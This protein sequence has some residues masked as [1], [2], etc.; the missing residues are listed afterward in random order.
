MG[1]ASSNNI[2]SMKYANIEIPSCS[3]LDSR[4]I[5]VESICRSYVS[6]VYYFKYQANSQDMACMDCNEH[7][8]IETND[9][10]RLLVCLSCV[11][12]GCH[13]SRNSNHQHAHNH[14]SQNT[15][16]NIYVDIT[17][18][19]L[20]SGNYRPTSYNI[21]CVACDKMFP[22]L[23]PLLFNIESPTTIQA[24]S[25][26]LFFV[27]QYWSFTRPVQEQAI[28]YIDQIFKSDK[29]NTISIGSCITSIKHELKSLYNLGHTCFMNCIIQTCLHNPYMKEFFLSNLHPQINAC[30]HRISKKY[31]IVCELNSL[32]HQSWRDSNDKQHSKPIAPTKLLQVMWHTSGEL[33]SY[34][35]HD[36]H[37]FFISLMNQLHLHLN[38][39]HVDCNCIIHEIFCGYLESS[40]T[41]LMCGAVSTT[42]DPFIDLSLDMTPTTLTGDVTLLDKIEKFIQPERLDLSSGYA[43]TQC[44]Q[45]GSDCIKQLSMK[46]LPPILCFHMKRFEQTESNGFR[47][48][49][50]RLLFPTRMNMLP[51]L[52]DSILS[53]QVDGYDN[54]NDII[55]NEKTQVALYPDNLIYEL[56]AVI[57][58]QGPSIES[59]HYIAYVMADHSRRLWFKMEDA[60]ITQISLEHVLSTNPY[61]L[62]YIL[63]SKLD[64][65]TETII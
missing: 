3:H 21:Y 60:W 44:Q 14:A 62:F 2:D 61:M 31:C 10:F 5:S 64:Y 49:D 56:F 16:H 26:L 38:G 48:I 27:Q 50:A 39:T 40:V 45:S 47:K 59:G 35:Q 54:M 18:T 34:G 51:F 22:L 30:P 7:Y 63:K 33:A 55:L 8:F 6:I 13:S 25:T 42:I 23:Y 24:L 28:S 41:C 36:A 32:F 9:N 57:V 43:C 37:E 46:Q 52:S 53:M 65:S 12:V 17:S 4:V 11:Y 1:C 15:G 20:K 58:H 29:N 19:S